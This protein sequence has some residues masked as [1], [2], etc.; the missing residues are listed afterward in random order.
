MK[1]LIVCPEIKNNLF[2]IVYLRMNNIPISLMNLLPYRQIHRI[3]NNQLISEIKNNFVSFK[4]SNL[5]LSNWFKIN[6][7][8][9]EQRND[10]ADKAFML[11]PTTFEYEKVMVNIN[12]NAVVP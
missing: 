11:K 7:L 2:T 12:H 8:I 3:G 5:T 6:I 10:P 1:H 9:G 4:E